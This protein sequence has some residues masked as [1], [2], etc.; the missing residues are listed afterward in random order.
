MFLQLRSVGQ[1]MLLFLFELKTSTGRKLMIGYHEFDGGASLRDWRAKKLFLT[2]CAVE[3]ESFPADS[4]GRRRQ[5]SWSLVI[6]V[7]QH[8]TRDLCDQ[9]A[10]RCIWLHALGDV[11]RYPGTRRYKPARAR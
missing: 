1:A 2:K 7:V 9:S 10:Q 5:S 11:L 6:G 4:G 8:K 3:K